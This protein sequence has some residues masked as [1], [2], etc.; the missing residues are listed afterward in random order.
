[1]LRI[2][3]ITI[4][5]FTIFT[6]AVQAQWPEVPDIDL[7]KY[8][9]ADFTDEELDIPFYLKHFHTFA[10]S[11]VETGP[12]KG[13]INIHVW[14]DVKDNKPYNAR[15][16]ENILSLA[17][18]YCTN[19]PWNIYYNSPALRPRLEAALSFWFHSQNSDGRFS[20]YG[21]KQWNLPAT[22]FSTKFMGETLRLLKTGPAIDAEVLKNAIEADRKAIMAVLTMD[23]LYKHGKDYSNQFTN[24]WAGGLAYLS[25]FPDAEI[26][27]LLEEKIKQSANDF[28]SPAGFFYEAGGTDFGYNFN[29]HHSNLWMAYHYSRNT[30]LANNF[31]EEEKRYYN[32]IS[33]NAVPEKGSIYFTINR[34]IE[35]RQKATTTVSYFTASPLG[36]AVPGIRAFNMN[37]EE[38]KKAIADARKNLEQNWPNVQPL[39]KGEFSSFS[40]YAFLHRKHYQWYP[41]AQQK[42][43]AIKQLPYINSN[44]FIHQK[45]DSRNP[46]VFTFVRQPG[47]YACFNSG[48]QLKPQ[49]RYGIGLLWHPKAGSFLQSQTDT[50]EAAWGTKPQGGKLYEADTL[51]ASF[52]ING[53]ATTPVPG[54]HDLPTGILTVNYVLGTAGKKSISFKEKT[55]EVTITHAGPFTEYIPLLLGQT[56]SIEIVSPGKAI[57]KKQDGDITILFNEAAKASIK[58]MTNKVGKQQVTTL[59]IESNDKLTYSFN[60]N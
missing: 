27:K 13:F 11:V 37:I 41:S 60:M 46:T 8:K 25:L 29:T 19:R 56:D 47:Y 16:M 48:P 24:V 42:E 6:Q 44:R 33:Y 50:D 45:M 53:K 21:P 30:P 9:P 54:S 1:M 10:N 57:L 17:W 3:I 55:I 18:F 52:T 20:E 34:P 31:I 32:W 51:D 38:K 36:E 12:D 14:R 2:A 28:Q 49:Q 23:D 5:M 43:A 58:K 40:P 39:G 35:M 4:A 7:S 22:A 15:I 26:S 59:V